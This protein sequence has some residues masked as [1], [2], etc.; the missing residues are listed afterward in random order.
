MY[1]VVLC[2]CVLLLLLSLVCDVKPNRLLVFKLNHI[3]II[4]AEQ[5]VKGGGWGVGGGVVVAVVMF[6]TLNTPKNT[7][8]NTNSLYLFHLSLSRYIDIEICNHNFCAMYPTNLPIH[9]E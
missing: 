5:K 2:C 3:H 4:Q 1:C 9:E 6:T 7:M 8:K